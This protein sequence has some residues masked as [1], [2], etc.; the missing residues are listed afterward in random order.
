[1]SRCLWCS[2]CMFYRRESCVVYSHHLVN[3]NYQNKGSSYRYMFP[4]FLSCLHI[5]ILRS[6]EKKRIRGKLNWQIFKPPPPRLS[7]AAASPTPGNNCRCLPRPRK[8]LPLPRRRLS[9]HR[10][11]ATASYPALRDNA[12]ERLSV[13]FLCWQYACFY[14]KT[15]SLFASASGNS[16]F[17]NQPKTFQYS[18]I[19]H[20]AQYT[21]E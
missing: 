2:T 21:Y 9:P 13:D 1:M 12:L 3:T 20:W 19:P 10:A 4:F 8:P 17:L 18:R 15:S 7:T 11:T 5:T 14:W 16:C 6:T